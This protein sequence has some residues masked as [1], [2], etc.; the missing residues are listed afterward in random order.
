M[1]K[2]TLLELV[3]DILSDL[4]SDTVNSIDDSVESLQVAQIV[5][6]TF[7]EIITEGEWPHLGQLIQ[8]TG[9]GDNTVPTHMTIPDN[10]RY[11]EW[12]KY[13]KRTSTDTKDVYESVTYMNPEDFMVYV[14]RRDSSKTTVTTVTDP[15]SV[16]L[17]IT[18]DKA[19]TYYTSFD[20]DVIVFDSY[21]SVVDST[22]Q[23]AKV[24]CYGYREPVFTLSDTF[25]ADLPSKAF[26]YLLSEA[27]SVAFN[28]LKQAANAKEEQRATRQRR[29]LSQDRWR[30]EGGISYPNYGRKGKK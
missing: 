23:S 19:P 3:Q 26:P 15:S 11:I 17:L 29:R 22:L 2:L 8:L 27:K 7:F 4:D 18:N 14:N 30:L 5:K 28:T 16:L 13:N 12:V 24:Q 20:N 25:V 6:T 10:V 21:D 1:A 9:S